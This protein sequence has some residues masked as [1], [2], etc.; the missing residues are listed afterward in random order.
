MTTCPLVVIGHVD[1][2]KTAL[3]RALTC[4][5]TDRLPEEKRR[6][7]SIVPGFAHLEHAGQ[8]IDLIDAP[9]HAD[10][11][12]AMISGACGA[13]GALL[14]ISAVDGIEAQ[15]MEHIGIAEALG[16]REVVIAITKSD[17]L[18]HDEAA[19][20]EADLRA[21]LSGTGFASA[22][23]VFC[24]AI[25]GEGIAALSG[26]LASLAARAG[27]ETP[28][29]GA[30][31]PIDRVFVVEGHGTV[32][33]GTLLGAP[34]AVDSSLRLSPAGRDVTVRRI[35][36][37]GADAK[38]ARPGER[39]ALNLRGLPADVVKPGDVLHA[40][41]VFTPAREADA[42]FTLSANCRR[43]LRHMDEVRV[44]HGTA[45]ASAQV[46]LFGAPQLNP[47]QDG[48]V[49]LKFRAPVCLYA[50]QRVILRRLSPSETLGGAQILDPAAPPLA[51]GKAA[52]QATLTAARSRDVPRLAAALAKEG[53][54]L[55]RIADIARLA[56]QPDHRIAEALEVGF[57]PV[58]EAACA[59]KDAIEAAKAAYL[60]KLVALHA[61]APLR[62]SVPRKQL[63]DPK[64]APAFCGHIEAQ[65]ADAGLITLT[66]TGAA[67]ADHA[68][69]V[70]L[71][72][73][74]KARIEEI[75]VALKAAGLTAPVAGT[76]SETPEDADL[77]ALLINSGRVIELDNV[78]LNQRLLFHVEA[79]AAAIRKLADAFPGRTAFTTGEARAALATNR[80]SIV[81]LLEH[82]DGLGVT[83][84]T[85]DMR[86]VA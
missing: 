39:T 33:T 78:A 54:G 5:D 83:V 6:G 80:K 13:R 57:V 4:Q 45:Q 30:F 38:L 61:A 27:D 76:F 31:L 37:R 18:P 60:E 23:F 25:T 29:V 8:V 35:E 26:A 86:H 69:A 66:A 43:A 50:G 84:R 19:A 22:P 36:V 47:G 65:L 74:H 17:L 82:L 28:P 48:L 44:H 52:R 9:G 62:L 56:R 79:I 15:T 3:V 55:A 68:P 59:P 20:R 21:A 1:H 2:G 24:S 49:R 7:L 10:F 41:V 40:P 53:S 42:V 12:R 73:A 67:M 72:L 81:P 77:L 64:L 32:V 71:S 51:A 46:Q 63:A 34:V 16:V 11:I 85:G 75:V 58:G 70:H 14:V